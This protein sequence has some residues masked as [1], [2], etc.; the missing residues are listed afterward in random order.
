SPKRRGLTAFSCSSRSFILAQVRAA[1]AL[2]QAL[3]VS[4]VSKLHTTSTWQQPATESNVRIIQ[5]TSAFSSQHR[6][7][8]PENTRNPSTFFIQKKE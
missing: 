4:T 2:S 5:H 3:C 8:K 6:D 7:L 1:G